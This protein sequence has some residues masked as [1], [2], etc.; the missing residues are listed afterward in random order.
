[1][2]CMKYTSTNCV[3]SESSCQSEKQV[4]VIWNLNSGEHC[5]PWAS[6]FNI[7]Y[8][9]IHHIRSFQASGALG[10][11]PII[12]SRSTVWLKCQRT[13]NA[14]WGQQWRCAFT[15][16]FTI[17]FTISIILY[18]KPHLQRGITHDTTGLVWV[19]Q[20]KY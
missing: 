5:G 14:S 7:C 4:M 20:N 16:K 15:S 10:L 9:H 8:R 11:R 3:I 12:L 6:C 18:I 2:V 19:N 13:P 1:M 17:N